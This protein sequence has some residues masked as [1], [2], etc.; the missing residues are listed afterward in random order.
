MG[1]EEA[2][3]RE[4]SEHFCRHYVIS[5]PQRPSDTY[6]MSVVLILQMGKL[7]LRERKAIAQVHSVWWGLEPALCGSKA[8]FLACVTGT[9]QCHIAFL[10]ATFA[11]DS[12][13][14]YSLDLT[15]LLLQG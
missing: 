15:Y 2:T 10:L 5:P 3:H 6:A 1:I 8:Q 4:P 13:L 7:R 11:G 9:S 14:F 12:I